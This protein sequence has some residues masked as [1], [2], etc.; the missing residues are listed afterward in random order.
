MDASEG[1]SA[2]VEARAELDERITHSDGGVR[3]LV[4][5]VGGTSAKPLPL[6]SMSEDDVCTPPA[7]VRNRRWQT[8]D[9]IC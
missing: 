4:H 8:K 1:A 6:A 2:A 3:L 7:T 5:C 9:E